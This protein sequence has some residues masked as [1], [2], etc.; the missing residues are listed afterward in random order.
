MR[1]VIADDVLLTR[2]G[3]VRVLTSAGVEVAGEAADVDGLMR[4]VADSRP[5]C[6][7]VDIRMP[8][9][10]TDEGIV[11][12]LRIRERYPEIAVLVLSQYVE[13]SY[14]LR[15]I[16]ENPE[17]SGYLLKQRVGDPAVLVDALRRLVAGETVVDPALVSRLLA[18]RRERDPVDELSARER[19]VLSLV[20][21]G[22]S[23]AEI[24]RRLFITERTVEAHVKQIFLKLGIGYAPTSNRRVLAVLAFLRSAAPAEA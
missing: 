13:P 17:R 12:A 1:V 21:E 19:E 9:T 20:A 24:G 4:A 2:E 11:G 8:P 22:L 16:E 15:L 10:Q 3:L 14:A 7:I 6:A 18:R 5:D 23:N